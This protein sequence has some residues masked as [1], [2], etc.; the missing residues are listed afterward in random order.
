MWFPLRVFP[1]MLIRLQP[2]N[3]ILQFDSA[4]LMLKALQRFNGQIK[5]H[6]CHLRYLADVMAPLSDL[7]KKDANF[8]WTAMHER[9]FLILKKML[10]VAA[11]LQAPYL[12]IPFHAFVDASDVVVGVVLMQEASKGQFQ[13]IYY[14][15]KLMSCPE[16]NY[17][18]IEREALGMVYALRK[19][20]HYLLG[21]KVLLHVNHQALSLSD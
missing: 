10:M 2:S 8:L 13:P 16:R 5:W 15:S 7:T 19:L 3:L 6:S 1:L 17:S 4:P 18:I 21:N 11:I 14:A 9:A 12:M 20:R